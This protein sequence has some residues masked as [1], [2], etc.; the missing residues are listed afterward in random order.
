MTADP[1]G[2][3]GP[4]SSPTEE[5][6]PPPPPPEARRRPTAD[7]PSGGVRWKVVLLVLLGVLV[8]AVPVGLAIVS[9]LSDESGSSAASDREASEDTPGDEP[10]AGDGAG[11]EDLAADLDLD[12]LSGTDEQ[13]GRLLVDVDESERAMIAF[14]DRLAETLGGPA[15]DGPEALVE[16][17]GDAAQTGV[18]RLDEVRPRL[19]EPVDDPEVDEVRSVYLEHHDVWADYLEAVAEQPL[20]IADESD[21][22]R[23]SL[24]INSSAEAFARELRDRLDDDVASDVREVG[25]AIL[26]RGFD[27]G[28]VSPD[29]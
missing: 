12:A 7:A 20:L 16:E 23:W 25:E 9:G 17:L 26:A 14:Q 15:E 3:P 18:E 22:E 29:V 8:V 13:L 10:D 2:G 5:P 21:S 28:D 24:S 1:P 19:A 11:G 4:G 27:R 6:P